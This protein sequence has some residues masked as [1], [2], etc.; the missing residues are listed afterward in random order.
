MT[1]TT[2]PMIFGMAEKH[3]AIAAASDDI[4]ATLQSEIWEGMVRL[5]FGGEQ[6]TFLP[7]H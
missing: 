6:I 1:I 7:Q 4:I 2:K 3:R 5:L